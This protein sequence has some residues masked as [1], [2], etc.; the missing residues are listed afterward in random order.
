M[1]FHRIVTVSR[2]LRELSLAAAQVA[3]QRARIPYRPNVWFFTEDDESGRFWRAERVDGFVDNADRLDAFVRSGLTPSRTVSVIFHEVWHVGEYVRKDRSSLAMSELNAASFARRAPWSSDLDVIMDALD[4]E[5]ALYAECSGNP[6][7]IANTIKQRQIDA[8]A[9]REWL[10]MFRAQMK[11]R[12]T[13][14]DDDDDE[15]FAAPVKRKSLDSKT[16][17][18][19]AGYLRT[20]FEEAQELALYRAKHE[21]HMAAYR[22][23]F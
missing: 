7:I 15:I 20:T 10:D 23:R 18:Q 6:R 5:I 1:P 19:A 11:W 9:Q 8:R 21:A 13:D 3:A 12:A 2:E 22:A 17:A 16:M 14:D 4:D